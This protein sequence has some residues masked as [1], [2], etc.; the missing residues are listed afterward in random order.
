MIWDHDFVGCIQGSRVS[1]WAVL[2]KT[3]ITLGAGG[4]LET[5]NPPETYVATLPG[6]AL[7]RK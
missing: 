3:L 4:F 6:L 7:K 2:Y 5:W 1:G